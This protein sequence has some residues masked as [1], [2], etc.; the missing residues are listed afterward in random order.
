[1]YTYAYTHKELSVLF[2][3]LLLN[4]LESIQN[5][6]PIFSEENLNFLPYFNLFIVWH[7]KITAKR[8]RTKTQDFSQVDLNAIFWGAAKLSETVYELFNSQNLLSTQPTLK[9]K[10]VLLHLVLFKRAGRFNNT[11]CGLK[12]KITC[13]ELFFLV[14]EVHLVSLNPSFKGKGM[15]LRPSTHIEI[16]AR[17]SKIDVRN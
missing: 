2:F 9:T 3:H 7:A 10:I 6:K 4:P 17:Q 15:G 5:K 13:E 8:K 14:Q 1:M 16:E 11:R 12:K